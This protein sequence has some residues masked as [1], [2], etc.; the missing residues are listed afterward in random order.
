MSMAT[1]TMEFDHLVAKY[2]YRDGSLELRRKDDREGT[3]EALT[4]CLDVS[5]VAELKEA[6]EGIGK[7]IP[8]AMGPRPRLRL[9]W[10]QGSN[11]S[12]QTSP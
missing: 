6:L 3:V 11:G 9:W 5:Q 7:Q 12:L 4:F 10:T 8:T 2:N 1:K